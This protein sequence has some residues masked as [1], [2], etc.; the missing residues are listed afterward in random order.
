MGLT[1]SYDA[2]VAGFLAVSL[3]VAFIARAINKAGTGTVLFSPWVQF[4]S[5]LHSST[6]LAVAQCITLI[7]LSN[8]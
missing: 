6:T 4:I 5:E 1:P 7:L 2:A 3:L 8:S